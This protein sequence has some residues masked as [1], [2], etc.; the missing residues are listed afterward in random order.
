M[1]NTVDNCPFWYNPAQNLPP[2]P[3]AA[4]DPDCDGFSTTLENHVGTV[5]YAHCGTDAWPADVNNDGFSDI[6]DITLL[7]GSFGKSVPPAPVRYDIAPDPSGDNFVDI[8]DISRMAG[9]FGKTCK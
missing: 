5:S 7:A 9:F 6:T 1:P 3:V 4:N 8:T 2:W